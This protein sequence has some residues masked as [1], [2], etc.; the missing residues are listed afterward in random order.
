M[1]WRKADDFEWQVFQHLKVDQHM[2]LPQPNGCEKCSHVVGFS[3]RT[4]IYEIAPIDEPMRRL[5]HG[6]AAE[7]SWKIMRV[8]IQFRFVMM[9]C[10]RF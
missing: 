10:S 9:V 2:Q 1:T 3:G 5:I 6:N 7:L 8:V 4:A